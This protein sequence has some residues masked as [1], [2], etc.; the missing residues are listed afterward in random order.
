MKS[1]ISCKHFTPTY[2]IYQN[3]PEG[4]C[5]SVCKH[6]SRQYG[7]R[8]STVAIFNPERFSCSLYR[9]RIE[10]AKA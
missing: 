9:L 4:E 8:V 10:E 5:S 3:Q 1:C 2:S 6:I 7:N